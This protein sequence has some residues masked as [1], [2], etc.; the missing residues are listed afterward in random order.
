MIDLM[1]NFPLLREQETVWRAYLE[2][3]MREYAAAPVEMQRPSFRTVEYALRERA[4]GWLGFPV[5]RTW[6]VAGGHHGLLNALLAS[7][8]A[9]TKCAL[10]AVSYPGFIDQCRMTRTQMVAVELDE[11]GM[12][13]ASLREVCERGVREG[14]PVRGVFTMP[15]VQNP[16]GFV[17]PLGRREEIVAIARE[18]G[19]TILEDEAY[20]YMEAEAPPSYARLAPERTFSVRGLS[21]SFAPGTRTGFLVAPENAADALVTALKCTATGTDVPQNMAALAMCEDGIVDRVMEDKRVE[22]AWRNRAA[23]EVLGA[24]CAPGAAC[25]WHLWVRL[26]HAVEPDGVAEQMR[27]RGVLVSSGSSS[28]VTPEGRFGLRLALGG[29]VERERMLDGVRLVADVLRGYA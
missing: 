20:A 24:A 12:L 16:L 3:A 22:G 27:Q 28:A 8:L 10:E 23:R 14:A 25:A 4:A 21:K 11:Q 1:W 26:S 17:T 15:T 5:E 13:P 18:F 29:E 7:G 6:I 9:G 19:L 2:R